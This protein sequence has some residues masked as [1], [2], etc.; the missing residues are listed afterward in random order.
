ML[1]YLGIATHFFGHIEGAL[2]QLMQRSA[3]S[4][5]I[6]GGAHC[7][8]QLPQNL[9]FAQ[10]HA[11]EASGD[12]KHMACGLIGLFDIGV[13]LQFGYAHAATGS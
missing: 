10:H 9:R 12:A 11:V 5:R 13:A 7:V 6:F 3:H 8:F 4:A 2:K 1:A